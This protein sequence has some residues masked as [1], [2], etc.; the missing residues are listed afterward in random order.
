M[1]LIN[2]E[3]FEVNFDGSELMKDQ[4]DI[5]RECITSFN[6]SDI[7]IIRISFLKC[8]DDKNKS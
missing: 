2:N 7:G 5:L 1:E 6:F 8:V 4:E 3:L